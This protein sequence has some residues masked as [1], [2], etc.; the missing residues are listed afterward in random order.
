MTFPWLPGSALHARGGGRCRDN[1]ALSLELAI[2]APA[3]LMFL[4]LMIVCGR[5]YL[6]GSTVDD[7][8]RDA[9]RAASLQNDPGAA[10]T[11]ALQVASQSLATQGLHCLTT[12]VQVPT[13]AFATPLGQPASVTVTVTCRVNLSDVGFPGLPGSKVLTGSFTSSLDEYRPRTALGPGLPVTGDLS[14]G[15]DADART[16]T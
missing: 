16:T 1:G 8:A 5:I 12:D 14:L 9:A 4:A 15:R 3:I 11:I 7:A 2:L 13:A 6:T 10:R